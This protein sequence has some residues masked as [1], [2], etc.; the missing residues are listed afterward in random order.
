MNL[1]KE[2]LQLINQQKKTDSQLPIYYSK[3]NKKSFVISRDFESYLIL[4]ST[5][6]K[7]KVN[8]WLRNVGKIQVNSKDRDSILTRFLTTRKEDAEKRIQ[9]I[10]EKLNNFDQF[11]SSL[12]PDQ[13]TVSNFAGLTELSSLCS[14]LQ[15]N[16]DELMLMRDHSFHE[17][18]QSALIQNMMVATVTDADSQKE[19]D[20]WSNVILAYP[21]VKTKTGSGDTSSLSNL[22]NGVIP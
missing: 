19:L 7:Q 12:L 1:S 6:S 22:R 3:A 17:K 11:K 13:R 10:D 2:E 16:M 20:S 8:S 15:A 21:G 14:V 5:T 9:E 4:Q 18:N